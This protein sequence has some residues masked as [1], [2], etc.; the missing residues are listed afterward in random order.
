LSQKKSMVPGLAWVKWPFHPCAYNAA[1]FDIN[2]A[3]SEKGVGVMDMQWSTMW[4]YSKAS[5]KKTRDGAFADP[6]DGPEWEGLVWAPVLAASIARRIVNFRAAF[7]TRSTARR[8]A[9]T[10][11]DH[12]ICVS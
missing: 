12:G 1:A 6:L 11:P 3:S 2:S 9:R 4:Q 10:A 7:Q 5:A 8:P